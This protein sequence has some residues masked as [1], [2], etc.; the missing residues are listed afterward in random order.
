MCFMFCSRQVFLSFSK[1]IYPFLN[2]STS[3]FISSSMAKIV[4]VVGIQFPSL[5]HV[6]TWAY[7]VAYSTLMCHTSS[8]VFPPT[9]KQCRVYWTVAL[10]GPQR[11]CSCVLILEQLYG[12][13]VQLHGASAL[14]LS[15]RPCP[16]APL[17]MKQLLPPI[18]LFHLVKSFRFFFLKFFLTFFSTPGNFLTVRD[19]PYGEKFEN[20][21]ECCFW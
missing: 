21:S 3:S 11:P 19:P 17:V 10:T 5:S 8:V 14:V 16:K 9:C 20:I 18:F 13:P 12:A 1:A 2:F 15:S 6:S 7:Y 4:T